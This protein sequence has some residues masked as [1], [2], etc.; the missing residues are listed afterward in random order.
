MGNVLGHLSVDLSLAGGVQPADIDAAD[1]PG[2]VA[3]L[4]DRLA[5]GFRNAAPRG[6]WPFGLR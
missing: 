1:G 5:D 2:L 3:Q 4:L 6:G